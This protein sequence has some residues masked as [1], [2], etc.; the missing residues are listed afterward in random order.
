MTNG[1][2]VNT[3][4]LINVGQELKKV[5]SLSERKG[6]EK[7]Q[8][9]KAILDAA[10]TLFITKGYDNVSMND[11]AEAVELSKGTLYLYFENKETLF[12]AIVLQGLGI[13]RDMF[14]AGV[15]SENTGMGKIEATGRAFFEFY[16]RYPDYYRLFCYAGSDRF[17]L[18][19]YNCGKEIT[20]VNEEMLAIMVEAIHTGV[21]DGTIR[22][23]LNP[24]ELAIF[25]INASE[26]VLNLSSDSRSALGS[27]GIGYKEYV[28]HAMDFMYHA[29]AAAKRPQGK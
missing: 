25:L 17:D 5:M 14:R 6:R 15:E 29:M 21:R 1:H 12:L 20:A 22:N 4:H 13:M 7:E 16:R 28:E 8:R 24:T 19:S 2:L 9:R 23:D 10:F 11:I 18:S 26:S 27:E 3:G